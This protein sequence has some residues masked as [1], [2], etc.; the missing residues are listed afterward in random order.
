[1]MDVSRCRKGL[2]PENWVVVGGDG[3][4]RLE[5]VQS[6]HDL[7]LFI[8]PIEIDAG[9][10]MIPRPLVRVVEDDI[11]PSATTR[12]EFSCHEPWHDHP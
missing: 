10:V 9:L 6:L 3:G 11:I 2:W 8:Q 1:M 12:V 5:D 4:H 7:A